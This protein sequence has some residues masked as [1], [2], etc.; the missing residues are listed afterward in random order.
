MDISDKIVSSLKLR[1]ERAKY[2]VPVG[3]SNRHIHFTEKD[4]KAVF[5][6]NAE[7]TFYRQLVQPGFFAAEEK[8]DIIGPKG[9]IRNVRMIGPLRSYTQVELSLSDSRILGINPPIRD[10]G[11]L[12]GTP[13]L[14]IK[15]PKG[16]SRVKNCA[17]ISKRHIHFSPQDARKFKINDQQEVRVRA[18][19]GGERELVFERVLC[20]VSDNYA[21]EFHIDIEEANSALLKNG[22][23]VYIV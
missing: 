7:P 10:S 14:V 21:L 18:G 12:E 1:I 19:I 15:G 5:G 3:V 20:R 17:I 9:V 6:S 16:E 22:D 11:K 2:P 13:G 8:V 4:F 23:K